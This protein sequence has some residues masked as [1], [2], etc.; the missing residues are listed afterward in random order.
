MLK[1]VWKAASLKDTA[2]AGSV[3]FMTW[4]TNQETAPVNG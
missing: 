4:V 1:A 3:T 2:T